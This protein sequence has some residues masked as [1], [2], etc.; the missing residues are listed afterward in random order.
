M[1]KMIKESERFGFVKPVFILCF[2]KPCTVQVENETEIRNSQAQ[3]VEVK[4]AAGLAE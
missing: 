4:M 2:K 3:Q 1:R